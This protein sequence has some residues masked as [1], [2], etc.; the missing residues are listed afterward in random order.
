M[1]I[2]CIKGSPSNVQ[3]SHGPKIPLLYTNKT[4]PGY[5]GAHI[6]R[7]NGWREEF[8]DVRCSLHATRSRLVPCTREGPASVSPLPGPWPILSERA[9]P[10]KCK[11][12]M[13]ASFAFRSVLGCPS[14]RV[15]LS[16][17]AALLSA[18]TLAVPRLTPS[19]GQP[20]YP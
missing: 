1:Y 5:S 10:I 16:S 15:R 7:A 14:V 13:N 3:G 20:S 8:N 9:V 17:V 18:A 4:T 11:N 6:T 19:R 2:L 12:A